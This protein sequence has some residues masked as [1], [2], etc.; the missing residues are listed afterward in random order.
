MKRLIVLF[1][2]LLLVGCGG[3]KT[4]T[5]TVTEEGQTTTM[6]GTEGADSW[7]PEGGN[8]QFT[9]SGVEGQSQGEWKVDKLMTSGKYAGLCHVIFTAE[10]PE[11][12]MMMMDYYFSEDGESG[13][14]LMEMNGQ[15]FEQEWHPE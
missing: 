9:S 8:W 14:F 10:G 6:T 15:T 4:A 7:C 13:Y 1:I 3:G 11:G 12:D 2:V 5:R